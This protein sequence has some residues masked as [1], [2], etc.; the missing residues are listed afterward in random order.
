M[1]DLRRV[2]CPVIELLSSARIVKTEP[3]TP[4]REP[5]EIKT[6]ETEGGAES[7]DSS[8]DTDVPKKKK[9]KKHK[10]RGSSDGEANGIDVEASMHKKKK[11]NKNKG[12]DQAAVE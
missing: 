9:H 4:K 7:V 2:E 6:E 12:R 10:E 11:K 1:V 5:A 8:T 3:V